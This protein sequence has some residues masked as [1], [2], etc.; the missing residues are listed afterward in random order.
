[1]PTSTN[2][3][4]PRLR[5]I[6]SQPVLRAGRQ[7]ILLR[8]P[9]R[10]TDKIVIVPQQLAPMLALCDGTRDSSGLR[11]SLIVRYGVRVSLDIVD[12]ILAA[13]DEALLFD[14]DRYEQARE[15]AIAEFRQAPY[16]PPVL[17]GQSYPADA[18][19]LRRLL[20]GY[21]EQAADVIP[22]PASGRGLVSPHIDF[23]R[24]GLV[25]AQVW[26]RASEM[27]RTADLAVILGTDHFGG[28][29]QITL[30]RQNYATPFGT[31]PTATDVVDA[32]GAAVG[33][34]KVFCE[35]LHH[36]GE[37]SIELAAVWLHHVREGQPC[38]L[39]PV[40][41][42][43]FS[44]FV[45]GEAEPSGDLA[46]GALL[47]V[48]QRQTAGRTVIIVAA[49]DL[50]H[51]GPAFGGRPLDFSGRARLQAIDDEIIARICAGDAEGFFH[52]IRRD[53]NRSNVCGLPPIYLALRM[54][55]PVQGERVAYQRCPADEKGT[56]LVSV[57]GVVFE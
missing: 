14:N 18:A 30:T 40:L 2:N 16:R 46:I 3:Q 33:A 20:E 31:L 10:L 44:D 27:V 45:S 53:G 4:L 38:Q 26:K 48:L 22:A 43:S 57:A 50:S 29:G 1:M 39:V 13:L 37:H 8:D 7:G 23:A 52:A 5:A 36:R 6:Q 54:L 34:E 15:Q 51:Q 49:A 19:E 28:S 41:L 56:S 42:G 17:A 35:E 24:G 47:D 9:L 11:A 55:E 12:R 25:Y 21:L 32:L